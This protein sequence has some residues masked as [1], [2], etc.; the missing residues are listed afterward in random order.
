MYQ[1]T[2]TDKIINNL[3][4]QYYMYA[5]AVRICTMLYVQ[6]WRKW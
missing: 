4:I 3:L 2:S 1:K 6:C 5:A